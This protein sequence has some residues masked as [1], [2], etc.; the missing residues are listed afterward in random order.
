MRS[1][2]PGEHPVQEIH[3]LLL[4]AIAP[5]PIAF[6]STIDAEGRPNLA[7]FSFFNIFGANPPVVVFS[8]SRTGRTN[9]TKDT[10]ENVRTVPEVVINLVTYPIVQ[11]TNLASAVFPRGT[12]EFV[13]AGLTPVPADLVRPFRVKESPVHLECKVLQ[14][15]ETGQ[16]P[17]AGNLVVCQIVKIHVDEAILNEKGRIDPDKADWVARM[18]GTLYCRASGQ[19][20][21]SLPRPGGPPNI[22]IDQLPEEIR[23]SRIFT[24]NDLGRMGAVNQLPTPEEVRAFQDDEEFLSI[25]AGE[26]DPAARRDQIHRYARTLLDRG[27]VLKAIALCI[28]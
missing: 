16:G 13:K 22:G 6:A 12:S 15:I 26:P 20:L 28:E 2:I 19:S 18:G 11:Q 23:N 17:S 10:Y 5:R 25:F 24:G 21:F 14:V 4:G 27:E 3:Q 7:P 8:P 1:Y 9:S